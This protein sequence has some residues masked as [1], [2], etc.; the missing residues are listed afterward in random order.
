MDLYEMT[1][2]NGYFSDGLDKIKKVTFD[3]FYRN[4][5]DNGGYAI[6]AG[7]EQVLELVKN[8]HFSKSDVAYF[9]SLH[10][11]SEEFLTYLESYHFHG[12]IDALPEG[13]V[14]YP[15]EPILTVTAPMLDAQLLETAILAEI[16]HQSL[17]ATKT[18][19]IVRAAQGRVVSD[20]GAR[21]AH[22]MDAAVYGARAAYIG[23]ANGTATVLAG[24]EFGI[25]VGG[26]MAHSWVMYFDDEFE[27][28][29][30]YA[31]IYPDNVVLLI[32]TYDV[33]H[34]GLPN[35]I[36]T[37]KEILHPMGKRLKGVRI[38]SGDLAYL[39]KRVRK[40]LDDEGLHDCQIVASNSL[41]EYTIRSILDQG[42]RIDSLALVNASLLLKAIRSSVRFI[43]WLLS[44]TKTRPGRRA[45]RFLNPLKRLRI[46]AGR[47]CTVST[48][49][50][51]RPFVI[52]LPARV[53]RLTFR[54]PSAMSIPRNLGVS[55]TIQTAR[56][57]PSRFP[58]SVTAR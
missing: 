34:S 43:S 29:K 47:T 9:R 27:A 7:L 38:D 28:F 49:A 42:G 24:K 52:S 35:A 5:P 56:P 8:F 14:M 22:N 17:I 32:D 13:T 15:H 48:T 37:A 6:F 31:E 36:R 4:N 51:A 58:L 53:K 2:A 1:M 11:F 57:K 18:N 39:S 44:K 41:D 20:F 45:S 46:L 21:R 55:V 26:T 25:P 16:N 23:G 54:R 40:I 30:K 10:L 50:M 33:I 3:V 19:R 12:D